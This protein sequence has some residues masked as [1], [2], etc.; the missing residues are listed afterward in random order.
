[1]RLRLDRMLVEPAEMAIYTPRGLKIRLS[2][3]HAFGLMAR[4]Y[5]KVDAFKVLKTTEGLEV[6]PAALAFV[7]GMLS[8]FYGV[9]ALQ[10]GLC[11]FVVSVFGKVVT[12]FG[13]YVIPGLPTLGMPYS[14]TSGLGI[15]LIVTVYGSFSA[16]RSGVTAFFIG[17]I[18][19]EFINAIFHQWNGKR[20]Y[21]SSG[22]PGSEINF[23]IA[24][25][26]HASRVGCTTDIALSDAE[27]E[28][29]NWSACFEDLAEKWPEVV[30][31]FTYD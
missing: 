24:Y 27:R 20:I 23:F 15:L 2:I 22:I 18:L 13:L 10:V 14:Y 28:E 7:T 29:A 8:F 6:I 11:V 19:A 31:R 21:P 5:P 1:M 12:G 16:G 30:R 25:R 3:G 9:D 17:Y 26:T 4:L